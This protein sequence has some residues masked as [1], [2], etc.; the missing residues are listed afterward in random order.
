MITT[1]SQLT[2]LEEGLKRY[3][4]SAEKITLFLH[5][6]III[7]L[8]LIWFVAPRP[9]DTR[10]GVEVV[11]AILGA[12]IPFLL[13]RY[14][15]VYKS[16]LSY[17][18]I[19]L[20]ILMDFTMLLGLIASFHLQYQQS[21]GFSLRAT[22]YGLYFVFIAINTLRFDLRIVLFSGLCASLSWLSIVIWS[23]NENVPRTY[24]FVEYTLSHHLLLGAEIEKIM[25]LLICSGICG[26]AVW[27]TR[28]L[29]EESIHTSEIKQRL[30]KFMSKEVQAAL[31]AEQSEIVPGVGKIRMSA[32]M[33]I[34]LRNF[35]S[36]SAKRDVSSTLKFLSE[37]QGG[38]IDI[39]KK[40][41]G[42][43]DKF[44]GDG[45]LV[46]FPEINNDSNVT[47]QALDCA[48]NLYENLSQWLSN[49]TGSYVRINIALSYG[50][51]VFGVLGNDER[52]DYTILGDEVNLVAKLEKIMKKWN[53]PIVMSDAFYKSHEQ[54]KF[55]NYTKVDN[56]FIDGFDQP[57]SIY[58][59]AV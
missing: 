48:I 5:S 46:Y 35:S 19:Y 50:R 31:G 20:S 4:L 1:K 43:I 33:F 58:T 25:W 2:W 37:Y 26:V 18:V 6:A 57:I 53:D 15:F 49:C 45:A 34:D 24:S 16:I 13:L 17:R 54:N 23:I 38:I 39:V 36:F 42:I 52:L 41:G 29:L 9:V 14:Y 27:R 12:Y 55:V 3:S 10:F 11:P 47:S 21:I 32:V 28:G 8:F 59:L 40:Y 56:I 7:S 51:T 44:Q 30:Q 22:T